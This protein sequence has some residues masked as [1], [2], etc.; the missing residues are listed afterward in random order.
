MLVQLAT[1]FECLACIKYTLLIASKCIRIVFVIIFNSLN[2]LVEFLKV[3][4][5][6]LKSMLVEIKALIN[7][8]RYYVVL[9]V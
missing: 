8:Q 6:I 2:L 5:V 1:I 4:L 9:T 3:L 7:R